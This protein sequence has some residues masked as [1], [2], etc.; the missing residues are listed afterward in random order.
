MKLKI[1]FTSFLV[2]LTFFSTFTLFIVQYKTKDSNRKYRRNKSFLA[3]FF[4]DTTNSTNTSN[5]INVIYFK[6][7]CE[8][9]KDTRLA[10]V[11][12]ENTSSVY[13]E[14][15]NQI[16]KHLYDLSN[17]EI[18]KSVF[19]C[20]FYNSF[21]RGKSQRIISYS[22]Y[23]KNRF[24]YDKL[25]E[26]TRQL[27]VL[28]PGWT[29]RVYYDKT[30]DKSVICEVECQIDDKGL[31]LDNADFCD[32]NNLT[33]KLENVKNSNL[34]PFDASYIHSMMWR[35]L[36]IGDSFVDVFSSRDTDSFLLQREVD[37][38]NVWLKSDKVGHIMRDHPWHGTSM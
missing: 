15:T 2:V 28:Y 30:I 9:K 26:I 10:I 27:K 1:K 37:S 34:T 5:Q 23:N 36:P 4:A 7:N 3:N 21:R 17:D 32:I 12:N 22:L 35:W 18:E 24:F 20:D 38:V 19:T 14:K 33:F 8:C 29:M 16:S 31:L 6:H 11:K 25:K 13:F